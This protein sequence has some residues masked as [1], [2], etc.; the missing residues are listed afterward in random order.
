MSYNMDYTTLPTFTPQSIGYIVASQNYT[1]Y[2]TGGPSGT[3]FN[4]GVVP[5]VYLFTG[6]VGFNLPANDTINIL[7]NLTSNTISPPTLN[8]I[9]EYNDILYTGAGAGYVAGT[10]SHVFTI[11][12][13]VS[14]LFYVQYPANQLSYSLVRIA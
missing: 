10:L 9:C 3:I 5:G 12:T 7:F 11:S 2:T 8:I 1:T 13:N 14:L 4:I 6:L